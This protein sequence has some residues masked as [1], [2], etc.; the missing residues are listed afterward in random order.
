MASLNKES[1][2]LSRENS[3]RGS[4]MNPPGLEAT[5]RG[6]A[7]TGVDF[8]PAAHEHRGSSPVAFRRLWQ[9]NAVQFW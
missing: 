4:E 6:A 3:R 9:D 5:V 8:F 1:F 2:L 7:K